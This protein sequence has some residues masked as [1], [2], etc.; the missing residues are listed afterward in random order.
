MVGGSHGEMKFPI[1][2]DF[3]AIKE[4]RY[5]FSLDE[6]RVFLVA[7][8]GIDPLP[9]FC[10]MTLKEIRQKMKQPLP[11]MYVAYTAWH[12]AVWYRDNCFCGRC[13]H[14]TRHSEKERAMVCPQCKNIIYPRII[15]AVI[16]GIINRDEI[17]VTKYAH[18]NLPFYAL[19]A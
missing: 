6:N 4:C 3:S 12:F 5:L 15:P 13:G 11:Y 10:Y 8:E 1:R 18:R 2:G 14:S 9:G 19:V 16:V 17:L 7:Q